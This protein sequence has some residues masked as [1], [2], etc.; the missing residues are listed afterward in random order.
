[1]RAGWCLV[2][3]KVPSPAQLRVSRF[4]GGQMTVHWEAAAA[5]VVSYLIKWISLSGGVL[6]EVRPPPP[7][8]WSAMPARS[9]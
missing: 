1:M 5:D 8:V 7:S 2:A 6:R 9:R 3:V 4:S